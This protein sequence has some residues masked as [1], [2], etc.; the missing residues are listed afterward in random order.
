MD[1]N[2]MDFYDIDNLS[3]EEKEKIIEN[4]NIDWENHCYNPKNNNC[5]MRC[6]GAAESCLMVTGDNPSVEEM[7]EFFRRNV[8]HKIKYRKFLDTEKGEESL[9][10]LGLKCNREVKNQISGYKL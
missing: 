4:I 8:F 9:K 2:N 6:E 3:K 10:E 7:K 1:I 5:D